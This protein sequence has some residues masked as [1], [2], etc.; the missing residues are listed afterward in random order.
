[1]P[2]YRNAG[3]TRHYGAELGGELPTS[4]RDLRTGERSDDP[5]ARL[6]CTAA[7]YRYVHD[8]DYDG[9]DIPGAPSHHLSVE[10]RYAHPSGFSI[11]PW[12]EAVPASYYLDSENT[13]KNEPWSALGAR[14]EWVMQR[15]GLTVFA[16]GRNLLDRRYSGSVQVDNANGAYFEPADRRAICGGLR[17][18]P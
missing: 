4:R 7:R 5:T 1:M 15:A 16:E 17:W 9:S 18:T 8:G 13:V 11:T 10:L 14:A 3:R 12:L 6:T 2:S